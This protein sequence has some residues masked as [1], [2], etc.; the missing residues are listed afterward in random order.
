MNV[1]IAVVISVM[2]FAFAVYQGI[3]TMKRSSKKDTKEDTL[4]IATV[5]VKLE[6]IDKGVKSIRED[7]KDVKSDIQE[8]RERIIKTE[9]S[10]KQAHKRIDEIFKGAKL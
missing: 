3:S 4:Q 5:M 6:D 9:E 2:S 10:V 8:N 1:E 7:I